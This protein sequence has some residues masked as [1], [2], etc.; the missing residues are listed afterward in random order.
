LPLPFQFLGK[1]GQN[2]WM[3]GARSRYGQESGWF[4]DDDQGIVFVEYG[5]F[6]GE[7][8]AAAV[9]LRWR[10]TSR[11]AIRLALWLLLAAARLS[12]RFRLLHLA[13]CLTVRPLSGQSADIANREI[14]FRGIGSLLAS[15]SPEHVT[16]NQVEDE[17]VCCYES[18]LAPSF[19]R[20][21]PPT[22]GS[23]KT[24]DYVWKKQQ[25]SET[26]PAIRRILS[27]SSILAPD[28]FVNER[29]I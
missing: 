29:T 9:F 2:G 5:K 6:T 10:S 1:Q 16:H 15:L 28:S 22:P 17:Q 13:G 14:A 24:Q 18:E 19:V 7:T 3:R 12:L 23:H 26:T 20:F 8:R 11:K 21:W 4:V 27:P 25:V